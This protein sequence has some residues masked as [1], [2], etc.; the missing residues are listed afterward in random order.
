MYAYRYD[1]GGY[2]VWKGENRYR[3][4]KHMTTDVSSAYLVDKEQLELDK[5]RPPESANCGNGKWV[6]VT[7]TYEVEK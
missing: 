1:S 4:V 2:Y 7:V 5:H 6:K 3:P